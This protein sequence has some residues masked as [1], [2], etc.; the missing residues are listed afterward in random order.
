MTTQTE[1]IVWHKFPEEKPKEGEFY[2]ALFML[3]SGDTFVETLWYGG[4]R[5]RGFYRIFDDKERRE[6]VYA[7]AEMP[8]GWQE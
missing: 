2:L 1:T 6:N 4:N 5:A 3:L 8:R 7:W